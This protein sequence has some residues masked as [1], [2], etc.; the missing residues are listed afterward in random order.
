MIRKA[1]AE[2]EGLTDYNENF[3]IEEDSCIDTGDEWEVFSIENADA[4]EKMDV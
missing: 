4:L 2:R 1:F 3:D